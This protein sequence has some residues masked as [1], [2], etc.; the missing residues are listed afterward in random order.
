MESLKSVQTSIN[1]WIDKEEVAHVSNGILLSHIKEWNDNICSNMVGP[2][3]Y[4]TKWSK[5]EKDKYH[6]L[7]LIHGI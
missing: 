4:H 6:M 1:R 3:G 2:R 7:S 5:S